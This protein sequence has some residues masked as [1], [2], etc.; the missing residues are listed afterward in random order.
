MPESWFGI[1]G[2]HQKSGNSF[3]VNA[4]MGF[5]ELQL[6]WRCAG[7]GWGGRQPGGEAPS[8]DTSGRRAV[9]HHIQAGLLRRPDAVTLAVAMAASSSC[10]TKPISC[11]LCIFCI[12]RRSLGGQAEAPCAASMKFLTSPEYWPN[13]IYGYTRYLP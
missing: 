11:N 9:L 3:V 7:H 6:P 5:W 4:K 10:E 12:L 2:S 13:M 1:C 8:V